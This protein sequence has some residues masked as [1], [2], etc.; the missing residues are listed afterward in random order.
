MKSAFIAPGASVIGNVE[1]GNKASVWYGA[2]VRGNYL[3]F[4]GVIIAK[5]IYFFDN[6]A[7]TYPLLWLI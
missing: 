3:F 6:S 7:I 4:V 5:G 1:I 2:V